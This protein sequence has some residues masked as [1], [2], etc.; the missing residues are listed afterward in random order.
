MKVRRDEYKVTTP[1]VGMSGCASITCITIGDL[2]F[3]NYKHNN[4]NET[5]RKTNA[6]QKYEPEDIFDIQIPNEND[7]NHVLQ[8]NTES[9][10]L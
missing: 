8:S 10:D 6:D 2:R 4:E 9:D 3:Y 1:T 5:F 7:K